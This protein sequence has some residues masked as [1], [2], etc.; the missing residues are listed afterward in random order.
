MDGLARARTPSWVVGVLAIV[1]TLL[2]GAT[3][4]APGS[5]GGAAHQLL[6]PDHQAC[7]GDDGGEQAPLMLHAEGEQVETPDTAGHELAQL[8][9]GTV[10]RPVAAVLFELPA[11]APCDHAPVRSVLQV[12]RT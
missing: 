3:I 7:S 10:G 2:F 5:H 1:L 9:T 12:W 6:A 8:P 11:G 4:G